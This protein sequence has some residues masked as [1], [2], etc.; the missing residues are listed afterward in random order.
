M[1]PL[2]GGDMGRDPAAQPAFDRLVAGL[3]PAELATLARLLGRAYETAIAPAASIGP[4]PASER[5][6]PPT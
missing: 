5:T 2:A 1:D 4:A 6:N 3:T